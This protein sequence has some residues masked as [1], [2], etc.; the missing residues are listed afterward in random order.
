[1]NKI[2]LHNTENPIDIPK[3]HSL[4]FDQMIKLE[5]N[6]VESVFMLDILDY[7]N[8]TQASTILETIHNKLIK[9]GELIV[10]SPD[11]KQLIICMN[12][13]K[14]DFN[15]GKAVLY[16]QRVTMH[17]MEDL[18]NKVCEHN[19]KCKVKKYINTFECFL[20]FNKI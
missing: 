13:N 8:K 10:Q 5:D 18:I 2:H 16:D 20:E 6:S 1:M 3:Y 12:F 7:H 17:Q 9:D 15:Q 4:N 19:F 11:L 14:I